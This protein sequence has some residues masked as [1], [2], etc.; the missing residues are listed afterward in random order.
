V[1][2]RSRFIRDWIR[3]QIGC[4]ITEPIPEFRVLHPQSTNSEQAVPPYEAVFDIGSEVAIANLSDLEEFQRTWRLHD[5]LRNEQ[6]AYAGK[7]TRVA[8][9]G[10][11]HGG[12]PLYEL[13]GVPGVW[14]AVC[15]RKAEGE[16]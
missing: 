14:H 16:C 10:F 15:L 11:Y 4:Q 12:D 7:V 2:V 5:P 6:L 9:V 3:L 1:R 13:K 8:K